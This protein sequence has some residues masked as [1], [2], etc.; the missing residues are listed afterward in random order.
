MEGAHFVAT[1]DLVSLSESNI[2][3]C[4]WTN[5]GCN[6][7]LTDRAFKYAESHPIETEE[8]YPYHASSGLFA[9]KYNKSKGL[10]KV[11]DYADVTKDSSSQLKAALNNGPVSVA[12]QAD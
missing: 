7:G 10:V 8:D 11:T 6:G 12:I 2:V 5:L 4:S 1:G 3:D 9:C